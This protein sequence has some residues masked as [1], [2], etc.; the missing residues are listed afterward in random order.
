MQNSKN[1]HSFTPFDVG[2]SRLLNV[3]W[4]VGLCALMFSF[5]LIPLLSYACACIAC[6]FLSVHRAERT[7]SWDYML[8]KQRTTDMPQVPHWQTSARG[9]SCT[10]LQTMRLLALSTNR[11]AS[12]RNRMYLIMQDASKGVHSVILYRQIPAGMGINDYRVIEVEMEGC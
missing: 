10:I 5:S 4:F 3:G 7:V 6:N 9:C 1:T 8:G 2:P 11:M 12:G